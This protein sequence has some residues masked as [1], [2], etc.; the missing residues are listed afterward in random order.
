MGWLADEMYAEGVEFGKHQAA[1][2]IAELEQ[3]VA[4]GQERL[5]FTYNYVRDRLDSD[6]LLESLT[7]LFGDSVPDCG[8]REAHCEHAPSG[9]ITLI[10]ICHAIDPALQAHG[11][12]PRLRAARDAGSHSS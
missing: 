5:A 9:I 12:D 1:E 10:G 2:R 6:G 8:C 3:R 11:F 4:D 7:H